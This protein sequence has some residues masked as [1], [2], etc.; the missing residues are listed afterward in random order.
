MEKRNEVDADPVDRRCSADVNGREVLDVLGFADDVA[1]H[2]ARHRAYCDLMPKYG[3]ALLQMVCGPV[4]SMSLREVARRTKLSP[5]YLSL[6]M[7]GKAKIS[8]DAY[9]RVA[10][11]V[12]R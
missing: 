1:W 7:N 12:K 10:A 3:Q 4:G 11:L 8:M 5:T 6:V 9:V 2:D